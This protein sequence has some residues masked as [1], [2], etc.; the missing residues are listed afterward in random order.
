M[1]NLRLEKVVDNM[2]LE[3]EINEYLI[4][5]YLLYGA[6]LSKEID[7]FRKNL[8]TKYKKE[9]N[10]CYKDKGEILKY[11]KDFI[12]DNDI[13]YNEIFNSDLYLSLRKETMKHKMHLVRLFHNNSKLIKKCVKEVLK[14]S[15]KESFLVYIVHPRMEI[16]DYNESTN[17]IIWGSDKDKYDVLTILL[18]T[19]MKGKYGSIYTDS[20]EVVDSIIELAVINEIGGKLENIDSYELGNPTLRIIKRQIYPFWLMYLGYN[21][22]EDLLDKMMED[23]I[24]FDLDKYPIDKKMKNLSIEEFISFCVKNSKHILKLGNVLKIEQEEE[25]EII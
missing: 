17:T 16:I 15:F 21:T 5:W 6:S 20:T 1:I 14:V 7:K 4:A 18:L 11:G 8:Y 13:L 19:I 2:E 23:K 3:F 25:I 22:K 24:A 12:P 9:Y 10:F